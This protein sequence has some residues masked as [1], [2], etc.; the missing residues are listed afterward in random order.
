MAEERV[1]TARLQILARAY[2]HSAIL[3]SAVDIGLFTAVARGNDSDE[4]LAVAL[5]LSPLDAD[6]IVTACLALGLLAWDGDR[7]VNAPDVRGI[8]CRASRPTPVRGCPSPAPM[9]R[10][11]SP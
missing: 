5:D 1:S 11:G 9:L 6:R 10:T 2:C 4:K 3:F 8:W 7:L